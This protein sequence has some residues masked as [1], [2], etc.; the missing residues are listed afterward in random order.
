M[1]DMLTA[2]IMLLADVSASCKQGQPLQIE[3]YASVEPRIK[4]SVGA[5]CRRLYPKS[6]NILLVNPITSM[7]FQA[8]P[9]PIL[10][11]LL[12][13][14]SAGLTRRDSPLKSTVKHEGT[15]KP[16]INADFPDPSIIQV[17][18][19]WVAV[20]TNGGPAGDGYRK[21]QVA[22]EKD[23]LGEWELKQEDA[24]PDKEW[25]TGENAWAPDIRR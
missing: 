11:L 3:G 12:N 25:S 7:V 13:S 23:L 1:I 15:L 10:G 16:R 17:D 22:T 4:S 9:W 21:L 2:F 20:A 18:G 5:Q 6:S 19:S 24:L 8:L 14:V